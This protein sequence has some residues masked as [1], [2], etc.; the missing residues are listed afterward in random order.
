MRPLRP[1]VQQMPQMQPLHLWKWSTTRVHRQ[2][3][4]QAASGSLRLRRGQRAVTSGLGL[5]LPLKAAQWLTAHQYVSRA[6]LELL[7]LMA[8]REIEV[9][10]ERQAEVSKPSC[11]NTTYQPHLPSKRA[12][13]G[14]P[15]SLH[16]QMVSISGQDHISPGMMVQ[17][18]L[19]HQFWPV[20]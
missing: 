19:R 2:H 12:A 5:R 16:G 18:R 13:V 10:K 3:S 4:L 14:T 7:D 11:L 9:K 17:H 8:R 15:H 6:A 1:R 20:P